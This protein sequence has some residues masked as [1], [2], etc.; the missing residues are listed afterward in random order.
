MILIGYHIQGGIISI[1]L[2]LHQSIE[3]KFFYN[4]NRLEIGKILRELCK[5]KEVNITTAEVCPDHVYMLVEI[6]PKMGISSFMG[7]VERKEQCHDISKMVLRIPSQTQKCIPTTS[8][9]D[10]YSDT[11]KMTIKA[12]NA[13]GTRAIVTTET[14]KTKLITCM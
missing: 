14:E 12:R 10:L 5:R 2:C 3:D 6:P 1:I 13:T 9:E 8:G 4:D 7:F 11:L